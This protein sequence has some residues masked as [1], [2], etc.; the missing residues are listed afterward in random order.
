MV[1]I[2]KIAGTISIKDFKP[3]SFV[4]S[5]YKL[6]VKVLARRMTKVTKKVVGECQHAW[7]IG[8]C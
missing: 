1:L 5:M 6:I 7:E 3:I 4:G 2:L 8:R